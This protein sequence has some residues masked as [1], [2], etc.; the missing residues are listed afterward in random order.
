[1]KLID[2][3]REQC[4]ATGAGFADKAEAL[5]EFVRLAKKSPLLDDVD[6]QEILDGLEERES[7]GST[8]F[9]RGIA[10]PHCRLES[11]EDFVVG[12]VSIPEGVEF[13]ALDGEKVTFVAFIIAPE[14]A[15]NSHIRLLSAVSQTL[16]IPGAIEEM[17]AQRDPVALRESFLRLTRDEVED[18]ER[19]PMSLFHVVVQDED[20]FRDILQVLTASESSSIVVLETENA[21]VYLARMPL[22][23]GF[24]H[25]KKRDF[26][27]LIVALVEKRLANETVRR[28][29][30]VTG[31]LDDASGVM[32][33][34]QDLAY[35]AGS[36]GA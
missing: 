30:G 16:N 28:I 12:L 23:A 1:M 5:R 32:V 8:G 19:K 21:G 13:D 11:L 10:I 20:R 14:D 27:R 22:F 6:E 17:M 18:R 29:E 24:W 34:I 4:V 26:N 35:A 36:V 3:V 9:G 2:V 7:L 25:D 33:T 15:A 31:D